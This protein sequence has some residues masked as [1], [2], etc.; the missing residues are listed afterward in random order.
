M[1]D[2]GSSRRAIP[3][4][5]LSSGHGM[6][7]IGL[8]TAAVARPPLAALATIFVHAVEVGYRHFDTVAHYGSEES[9]GRAV[10]EA[11]DRQLIKSRDEVFITSELRCSDADRAHAVPALKETLG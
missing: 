4:V 10:A 11:L 6:P 7:V 3:K 2:A 9:I 5:A 8:G 1:G